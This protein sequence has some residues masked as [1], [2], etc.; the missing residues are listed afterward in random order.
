MMTSKG[1]DY[2]GCE[3]PCNKKECEQY[4]VKCDNECGTTLGVHE[5]IYVMRQL[6]K[7][8]EIVICENCYDGTW[9]K[10]GWYEVDEEMTV[11]KIDMVELLYIANGLLTIVVNEYLEDETD[12]EVDDFLKGFCLCKTR[13][14][15]ENKISYLLN[16]TNIDTVS[17]DTELPPNMNSGVLRYAK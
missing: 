9:I 2:C 5:S 17:R 4:K 6:K 14:E 11:Y 7:D 3:Y 8:R 10:H 15:I 1:M 13:K 12:E 16:W